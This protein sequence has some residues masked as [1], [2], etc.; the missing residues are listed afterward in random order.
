MFSTCVTGMLGRRS[1]I[2]S[3]MP[4]LP[5]C[6]SSIAVENQAALI[7][8]ASTPASAM[9]SL[10]ASSIRSSAP[11][12]QR[13]P[14]LEQPMPRI[15]TLSLIPRAIVDSLGRESGILRFI[16][17]EGDQTGAAFQKYRL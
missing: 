4:D 14:N 10:Y 9:H 17:G 11:E 16:E 5:T 3:G 12:S 1:V 7:W 15:A 8:L 6:T 2:D 13:S